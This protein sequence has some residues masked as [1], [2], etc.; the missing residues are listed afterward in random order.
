MCCL[1]SIRYAIERNRTERTL[2]E[3]EERYRLLIERSPNAYMVHCDGKVVFANTASLKLFGSRP[4]GTTAGQI[5]PAI[6]LP[7]NSTISCAQTS[8]EHP[9]R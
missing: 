5:Y 6:M 2:A 9:N 1:R 4:H 3:S 8:R 7:R